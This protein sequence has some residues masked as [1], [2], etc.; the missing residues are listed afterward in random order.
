MKKR[1]F[2]PVFTEFQ[3]EEKERQEQQQAQQYGISRRVTL[4]VLTK[5][6]DEL[7]N[8]SQNN[9]DSLIDVAD[10]VIQYRDHA[11]NSLDLAN[12]ALE[13]LISS[14]VEI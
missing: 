9:P 13:R 7:K 14:L 3:A 11:K 6:F 12:I 4:T 5:S 2:S 10:F 8:I 1:S